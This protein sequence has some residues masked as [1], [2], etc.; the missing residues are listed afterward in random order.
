MTPNYQ[1]VFR[2]DGKLYTD[3]LTLEESETEF[4]SRWHF[5]AQFN[6]IECLIA[7]IDDTGQ[8]YDLGSFE[9]LPTVFK[10]GRSGFAGRA[11]LKTKTGTIHARANITLNEN[12]TV[13]ATVA[14]NKPE[15]LPAVTSKAPAW[16]Q[17]EKP[18]KPAKV[19]V[20]KQRP[21]F[22][23]DMEGLKAAF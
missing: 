12:G 21:I 17:Q 5:A 2:L 6:T 16:I 9:L 11:N 19:K 4:L 18:V 15:A 23:E 8:A 14:I 20:K 10:T 22:P 13:N 1:T 3:T 7:G